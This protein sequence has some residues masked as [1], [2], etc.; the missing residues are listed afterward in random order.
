MIF[1]SIKDDLYF[2]IE[3]KIQQL[4]DGFTSLL[5]NY[6]FHHVLEVT[7]A[8]G[9]Y[10]NGTSLKGGAWGFKIESIERLE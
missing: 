5:G 6:R 10:L 8:V 7:L 9:N 1:A 4:L 2:E 3:Q